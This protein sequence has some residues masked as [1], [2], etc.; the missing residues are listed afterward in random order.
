MLTIDKIKS[1]IRQ[2]HKLGDNA[3]VRLLASTLIVKS[4]DDGDDPYKFTA[5]MTTD[6][7]DRQDEVVIPQGG[8]ISEFTRSGIL[9]WNHDYSCPI[10]FPNKAARITRTDNAIEMGAIFLKRPDDYVGEFFPDFARA[11]VT[12][13]RAAGINPGVSI[14]FIPIESRRP[15]K[16]DLSRWGPS[17]Q[18][19]HSKWKLLELAIAPVQANQDAVVTAVGKGLIQRAVAK[20]VGIEVQDVVV[21]PPPR[22]VEEL[23]MVVRSRPQPVDAKRLVRNALLKEFGRIYA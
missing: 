10:G 5:R 4:V 15:T 2:R 7:M 9:S 8:D 14:G 16:A 1:A 20:A 23:V 22:R 11:F 17:L 13:A 3:D 21:D 18:A 19:V 6:S 12:Q